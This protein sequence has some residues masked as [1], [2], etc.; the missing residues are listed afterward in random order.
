M[1]ACSRCGSHDAVKRSSVTA[2]PESQHEFLCRPCRFEVSVV[3]RNQKV[4]L[5]KVTFGIKGVPFSASVTSKTVKAGSAGEAIREV[6]A[7][8]AESWDDWREVYSLQLVRSNK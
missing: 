3:R 1:E 6:M 4:N 8:E 5:Y 2:G 7:T